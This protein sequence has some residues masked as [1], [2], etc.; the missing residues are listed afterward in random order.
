LIVWLNRFY[1]TALIKR[2][3]P[4]ELLEVKRE[5]LTYENLGVDAETVADSVVQAYLGNYELVDALAQHYGFEYYFF[6]QPSILVG[7]KPLTEEERIFRSEL[8]H[9]STVVNLF[10]PTYQRIEQVAGAYPN[11]HNIA[12]AFDKVDHQLWV[13]HTH[14]TPEGNQL[15]A[16]EMLNVIN[17][18]QQQASK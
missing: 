2:F 1:L 10:M 11:L 17:N 16:Q 4:E 15:I 9:F 12:D 18:L 5:T 3:L 14:V 8:D 13:E 7:N 6:W